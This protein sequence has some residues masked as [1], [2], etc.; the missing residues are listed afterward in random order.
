MPVWQLFNISFELYEFYLKIF[1]LEGKLAL[2]Y[3]QLM[4]EMWFGYNNSVSPAEFKKIVS[5][6]NS[7]VFI[8][9]H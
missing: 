1:F 4:K 2:K 6:Y 5:K 8:S 9:F 3:S 7:Q